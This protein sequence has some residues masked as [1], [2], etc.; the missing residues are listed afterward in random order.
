[1]CF[2][3]DFKIILLVFKTLNGVSPKYSSDL[4]LVYEAHRALRSWGAGLLFLRKAGTKT[5][6][7][8]SSHSFYGPRLLNSLPEDLRAA[9]SVDIFKIKLET[10]IFSKAFNSKYFISNLTHIYCLLSLLCYN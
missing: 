1:M 8:A 5:Y 3:I 7:E 4:L 10:Y 6:R 9:R 2:L